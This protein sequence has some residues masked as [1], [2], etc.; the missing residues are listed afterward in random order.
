[1]VKV[2]R[3][4][5][6]FEDHPDFTPT[7]YSADEEFMIN[8]FNEVTIEHTYV[9]RKML[10][11]EVG[12]GNRKQLMRGLNPLLKDKTYVEQEVGRILTIDEAKI[13]ELHPDFSKREKQIINEAFV[14][15]EHKEIAFEKDLITEL[16]DVIKFTD[17]QEHTKS[18]IGEDTLRKDID[19]LI[20]KRVIIVIKK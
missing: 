11:K 2:I 17:S 15:S 3:V 16:Q 4:N 10:L 20:E 6:K 5:P 14:Y 7:K 18:D 9:T 8:T 19:S 1:M 13:N 12:K